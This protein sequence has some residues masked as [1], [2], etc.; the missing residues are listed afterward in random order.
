LFVYER[1]GQN[2]ADKQGGADKGGTE[3]KRPFQDTR[4]GKAAGKAK[5]ARTLTADDITVVGIQLDV[6]GRGTINIG[7]GGG[8]GINWDA[9]LSDAKADRDPTDQFFD[10]D[11]ADGI[12]DMDPTDPIRRGSITRQT[13]TLIRAAARSLSQPSPRRCSG[14]ACG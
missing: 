9:D 3:E 4:L 11:S 1:G 10:M 14:H 8:G 6:P 7:P 5:L 2:M 12:N 13:M